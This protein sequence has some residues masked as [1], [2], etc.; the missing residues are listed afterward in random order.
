MRWNTHISLT[1]RTTHAVRFRLVALVN[2]LLAPDTERS[3]RVGT[4]TF[5]I[6]HVMHPVLLR[7]YFGRFRCCGATSTR[8]EGGTWIWACT[9]GR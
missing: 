2:T 9:P 8:D 5:L 1:V 7:V 6:L 3:A 4:L